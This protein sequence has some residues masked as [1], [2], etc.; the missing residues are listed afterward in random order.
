MNALYNMVIENLNRQQ[1]T[2]EDWQ[3][4]I[5]ISDGKIGPKIRKLSA[6]E[7]GILIENGKQA[8]KKH[9]N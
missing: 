8:M 9:L 1:L 2:T 5:S 3:R 6:E 7:I 4:T